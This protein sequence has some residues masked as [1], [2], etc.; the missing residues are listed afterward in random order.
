MELRALGDYHLLKQLGCGSLGTSYL[1]EHKFTRQLFVLKVLPEEL[2]SD[3]GFIRRFE[4]EV[5]GLAALTHPGLVKLHTVSHAQGRYFLVSDA[6]VNNARESTNLAQYMLARNRRLP[7]QMLYDLLFQIAETL[8]YA[9]NATHLGQGVSL[10]HRGIKLNNILVLPAEEGKLKVVVSDFGLSRII[11]AGAV[12]TQIFRSVA[13]SLENLPRRYPNPP[14]DRE[15]QQH[16]HVSFLQAYAF[17]APEQ[18]RTDRPDKLTGAVD[19]FAF[20]VLAYTLI[21]GEGPELSFP[22]PSAKTDEYRWNWDGLIQ[23]CL[24]RDP[25]ARPQRLVEALT[26]VQIPETKPI[27]PNLAVEIAPA[28]AETARRLSTSSSPLS[29]APVVAKVGAEASRTA[30]ATS[31]ET[32]TPVLKPAQLQR[33]KVDL[34]PARNFQ[35]DTAV[36]PYTPQLSEMKEVQ[37]LLT[38]MIVIHSGNYLRGST[39]GNRDEM[40]RHQVS[41]NSFAI[42]IHPVT[43]EQFVRFLEMMGGEKDSHHRDLTRLR[44]SRIKRSGGRLSIESGYHKHPVVGVTWYG[45]VL[46]A[47]WV[48]KRLPTEAEWEIAASGAGENLLYPTGEAIEKNQANFFSTDTTAVMSYPPTALG[49]YDMAGNVYEW[50]HDWYAY[51]YYE[52]SVQEPENPQGPLQGVYRV[53]RG[54]CWKSL[55]EDLRCS[56]RHRNNPGTVNGTYGFRCAADVAAGSD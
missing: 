1:A 40:P 52:S 5:R 18:K 47:Q 39:G 7:E 54:G 41:V 14:I 27:A 15:Q 50:C 30:P 43:N 10:V 4:E 20:G 37:P 48:G 28:V 56:R 6:V 35:I 51:N 21:M 2:V 17:L 22:F 13:A 16:L 44:D 38:D 19:R 36:T 24:R 9:H 31:K 46:Y 49:L 33:P 26:A 25:S 8:D 53:L 23:A 45:A 29:K 55:K 12:L 32:L 34:D 42:D 11:G 3:S